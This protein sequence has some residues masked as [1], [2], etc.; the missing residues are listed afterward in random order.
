M[1]WG[2]RPGG[3][4]LGISSG[5]AGGAGTWLIA[6]AVSNG[7]KHTPKVEKITYIAIKKRIH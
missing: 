6:A 2:S 5:A 1:G 7:L 3:S 4:V